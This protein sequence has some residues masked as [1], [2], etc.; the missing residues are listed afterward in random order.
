MTQLATLKKRRDEFVNIL[1]KRE[2]LQRATRE[3]ID[4][5]DAQIAQ[6]IA[7]SRQSI[8][9][10]IDEGRKQ[11]HALIEECQALSADIGVDFSLQD[12]G[13]M[14]EVEAGDSHWISSSCY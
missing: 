1:A 13:Y 12:I 11:I 10:K 7:S 2:T 14:T 5:I 9:T 8:Q 4:A 6:E 3:E